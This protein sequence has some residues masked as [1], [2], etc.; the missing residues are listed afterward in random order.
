MLPFVGTGSLLGVRYGTMGNRVA[1]SEQA[2]VESRLKKE[3]IGDSP[4][5]EF[6]LLTEVGKSGTEDSRAGTRRDRYG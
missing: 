4:A 2:A 5:L 1:S 3:I 6:P